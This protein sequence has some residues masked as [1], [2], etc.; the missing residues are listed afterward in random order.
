MVLERGEKLDLLVEKTEALDHN[1]FK[2]ERSAK[3]VKDVM[4]WKRIKFYL[5]IFVTTIISIYILLI[6][7]CGGPALTKCVDKSDDKS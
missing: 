7:I 1:A 4:L 3:K 6:F 5:C 2:F